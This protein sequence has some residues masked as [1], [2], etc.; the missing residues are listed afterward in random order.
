MVSLITSYNRISA[1]FP[2]SIKHVSEQPQVRREIENY[3]ANIAQIKTVDEF[4]SNARVYNVAL[5]AFGLEDMQYATA[6]VRKVLSEGIDSPDAFSLQLSDQRF[7][8]FAATFNFKRYGPATTSFDRAQSGTVEKYLRNALE[9]QNGKSNEALRL[10]LYFERKAKTVTNAYSVLADKALYQVVRT[11]L[12]LP[13]AMSGADI[14]KQAKI[15][16]EKL[17]VSRLQDPK[18]TKEIITRFLGRSEVDTPSQV[19]GSA[20]KLLTGSGSGLDMKMI[21]S[22]QT[23]KKFGA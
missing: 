4:M 18:Y 13:T 2:A 20:S 16:G 7:R 17:D 3:K 10:A 6:F 1:N 9:Q 19:S 12:G 11:S 15:I 14:D 5:K 8:D 22:L 23:L 21:L